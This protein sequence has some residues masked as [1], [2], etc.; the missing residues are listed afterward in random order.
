MDYFFFKKG[1]SFKKTSGKKIKNKRID[2]GK[3][4]EIYKDVKKI[5]FQML[6]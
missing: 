4:S 6:I 5:I 3:K 2:K 1:K